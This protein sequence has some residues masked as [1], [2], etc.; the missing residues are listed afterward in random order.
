MIEASFKEINNIE[1]I[2]PKLSGNLDNKIT[3]MKSLSE[4]DEKVELNRYI[5]KSELTDEDKSKIKEITGYS[6]EIVENISSLKEAMVY[7]DAKLEEKVI[8]GKTCLVRTDIDLDQI[9]EMGQS[10]KQR[11]ERGL[12]PLDKEGKPFEL[13]HIGQK[14]DSTLAELTQSEH[15]GPGNDGILHNKDIPSE[16]NRSEFNTER[17]NHWKD[18]VS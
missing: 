16:I 12:A 2:N 6:D 18:R 1:R 15:R 14:S 3:E 13:H 7:H 4:L 8:N 5:K 10:N 9:D 11:M 17:K